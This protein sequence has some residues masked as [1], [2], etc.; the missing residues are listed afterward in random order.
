MKIELTD[1]SPVKKSMAVEVDAEDVSKE[2]E[3]VLRR[4]ATQ[5]RLPGF[6]QGKAPVAMVRKRFAKE[7]DDDV[8]ERMITRAWR[9]ATREKG[10]MPIGDPVLEDL[11]HEEGMPFR[12]KTTFEVLPQFEVKGYKGVEARQPSATVEDAEVAAALESIRQGNA[13]FVADEARLAEPGDVIVADVTEHPEG[14]EASTRER[15]VVEVGGESNPGPFNAKIAGAATGAILDFDVTYSED[16]HVPALA[17]KK[18]H[19]GLK[20]HEVKRKEV[21]PLDDD[22]AKDLGD[23]ANL[24]ALRVRVRSD[25]QERKEAASRSAVRQA[26]LDKVLLENPVPLPDVL[27]EEEIRHRMEDMVREMMFHGVD[28]RTMNLDWKQLRDRNEEPARKIV[29][30]RLVLDAIGLAEGVRVDRS[31]VEGRIRREAE[32]IGEGY[33]VVR[34]RL[35]KG[36]GLQALETQMVREKSLDLITSIANIQR[37]E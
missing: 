21:P 9:D 2:T 29:H 11:K 26:V 35:A 24:D 34:E 18:V 4:Y 10:L 17:G 27:V 25:L 30:A 22:L 13:R 7:I 37:P 33:D 32:R 3:N 14:G 19:Y 1:L 8:R 5:V 6:R 36:D 12:F 15:M 20:V 23:F 31:E 28:P 16:H